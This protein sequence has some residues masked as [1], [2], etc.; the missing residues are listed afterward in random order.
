MC[1]RFE[2]AP[3]ALARTRPAALMRGGSRIPERG[4]GAVIAREAARVSSRTMRTG[5]SGADRATA[6]STCA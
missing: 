6:A 2:V 1:R 5:A 4:K 3:D